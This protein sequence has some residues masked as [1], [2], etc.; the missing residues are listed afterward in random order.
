MSMRRLTKSSSGTNPRIDR[1]SDGRA[2][3]AA[4]VRL[5]GLC[6]D[7]AARPVIYSLMENGP[8]TQK[9]KALGALCV[10]GLIFIVSEITLYDVGVSQ[11]A[12][13]DPA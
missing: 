7:F 4:V 2:E 11:R 1:F 5:C 12:F 8:Y 9:E 3:K 10:G 6:G 13:K